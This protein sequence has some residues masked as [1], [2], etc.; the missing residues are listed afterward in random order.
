MFGTLW[1][2]RGKGITVMNKFYNTNHIEEH[3]SIWE[4]GSLEFLANGDNGFLSQD[5][6]LALDED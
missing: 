1:G 4:P 6:I 2:T 3:D 5:E